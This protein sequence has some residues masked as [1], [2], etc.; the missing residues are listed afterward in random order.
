MRV[1]DQLLKQMLNERSISYNVPWPRCLCSVCVSS[2]A[3]ADLLDLRKAVRDGKL[4][5]V[6]ELA[7]TGNEEKG[8][9]E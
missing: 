2:R 3:C 7:G 4:Q 5:L 9:P 6:I 1:T 8:T